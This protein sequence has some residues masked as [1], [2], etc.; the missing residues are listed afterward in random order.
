MPQV[1][2]LNLCFS[3]RPC[4]QVSDGDR[5]VSIRL[6]HLA[7]GREARSG[8]ASPVV[9]KGADLIFGCYCPYEGP[10]SIAQ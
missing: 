5:S 3:A 2:R 9:F 6:R 10:A 8:A 4:A 1:R 7:G